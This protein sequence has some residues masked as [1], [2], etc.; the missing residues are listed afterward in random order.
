MSML[1]NLA[2]V[3]VNMLCSGFFFFVT[4]TKVPLHPLPGKKFFIDGL[5]SNLG[6]LE[7][8][9]NRLRSFAQSRLGLSGEELDRELCLVASSSSRS[10]RGAAAP[11]AS[12]AA[13]AR[14][15]IAETGALQPTLIDS[16]DFVLMQSLTK[17]QH[18]FVVSDPSLPDN[19]IVFA[20]AGFYN[21][22][23]YTASD[24]IGRNCRLLQVGD[25]ATFFTSGVFIVFIELQ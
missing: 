13:I 7:E 19:P 10:K 15:I 18:N 22:T 20:S 17:A 1:A 4:F 24:I 6:T 5:K 9:N 12:P 11:A 8:E 23:G 14:T 16:N 21:M 2:F 3:S 25:Y